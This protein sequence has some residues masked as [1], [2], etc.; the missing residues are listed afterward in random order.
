MKGIELP[1]LTEDF[2]ADPVAALRG[3][4]GEPRASVDPHREGDFL[5]ASILGLFVMLRAK[6][7]STVIEDAAHVAIDHLE[8]LRA[9]ATPRY[10]RSALLPRSISR[11]YSRSGG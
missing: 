1:P 11:T 3:V 5:A 2:T 9:E 6:A 4:A 10:G 8:A 7:P